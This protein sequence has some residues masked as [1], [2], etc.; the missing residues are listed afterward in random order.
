MCPSPSLRGQ[1]KEKGPIGSSE[2]ERLKRSPQWAL[3]SHCEKGKGGQRAE[4]PLEIKHLAG[5]AQLLPALHIAWP[6]PWPSCQPDVGFWVSRPPTDP[7]GSSSEEAA[8]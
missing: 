5:R 1:G 6:R 2:K 3:I 4:D 8:G 7:A